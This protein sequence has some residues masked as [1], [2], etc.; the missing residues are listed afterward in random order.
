[1]PIYRQVIIHC[2]TS[3]CDSIFLGLKYDSK[4]QVSIKPSTKLAQ[5]NGWSIVYDG[6][7][8]RK[9]LCPKCRRIK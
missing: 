3:G 7:W 2:D 4:R 9:V 5:S 8:G 6:G 1:M